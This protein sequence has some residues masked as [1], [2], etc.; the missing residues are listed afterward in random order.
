[1]SNRTTGQTALIGLGTVI[2]VAGL[3]CA[4]VGFAEFAGAD[5]SDGLG[6]MYLFGGGAFAA[7]VGLGIV[8]FT[9]ASV[10]RANGGYR[11]TIEEGTAARRGRFCSSCGT[12]L[13]PHARFCD[14]CGV[15]VG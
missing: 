10:M 12:P 4:V 3:A 9:R 11:I 1:M 13:S 6:S 7:V 14:S 15:A 8:A 5:P 2:L